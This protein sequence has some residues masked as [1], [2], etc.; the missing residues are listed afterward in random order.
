M[1]IKLKQV[2][3]DQLAKYPAEDGTTQVLVIAARL[4]PGVAKQLEC[5]DACYDEEKNPRAGLESMA[6]T[7]KITSAAATFEQGE[8]K[9]ARG[10]AVKSNL[11]HK[12]RVGRPK[13]AADNDVSLELHARLHFDGHCHELPDLME[14]INKQPFSL[15]IEPAQGALQFG[16][17]PGEEESDDDNSD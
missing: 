17:Q 1:K 7:C 2:R 14:A 12:F 6:L 9:A 4:T 15:E 3:W 5:Y 16:D 8:G 10:I 13:G 11:V